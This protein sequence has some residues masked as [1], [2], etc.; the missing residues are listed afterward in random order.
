MEDGSLKEIVPANVASGF[1]CF[2][3]CGG[4]IAV[5]QNISTSQTIEI[6]LLDSN[7]KVESSDILLQ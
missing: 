7:Y 2:S 5:F 1:D 3:F 6:N 4:G